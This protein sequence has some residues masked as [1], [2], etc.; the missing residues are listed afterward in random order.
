[1]TGAGAAAT[2]G[3]T[4]GAAAAGAGPGNA[5]GATATAFSRPSVPCSVDFSTWVRLELRKY[6][7]RTRRIELFRES[8]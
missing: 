8:R 3:A 4:C 7:K 1:M 2:A 6:D 5:A